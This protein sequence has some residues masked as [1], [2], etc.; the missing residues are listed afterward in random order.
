MRTQRT[1]T[2]RLYSTHRGWEATDTQVGRVEQ[3][4]NGAEG[5]PASASA[6]ASDGSQ[7]S[8]QVEHSGDAESTGDPPTASPDNA[9]SDLGHEP[10]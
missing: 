8:I 3:G 10:T 2:S 4:M 5:W 7:R 1:V 9:V 6:S